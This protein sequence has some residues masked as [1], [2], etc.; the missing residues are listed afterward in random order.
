MFSMWKDLYYQG[1]DEQ[2]HG[3]KSKSF[4]SFNTVSEVG[5]CPDMVYCVEALGDHN[6]DMH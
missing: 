3:K 4:D 6:V 1:N 5:N 2:S